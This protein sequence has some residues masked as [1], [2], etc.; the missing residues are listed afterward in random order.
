MPLANAKTLR[1]YDE[2]KN[3]GNRTHIVILQTHWPAW[4][5]G[6]CATA[7]R[8]P[9]RCAL[10]RCPLVACDPYF[11]IWSPADKLT[12]AD[13]VHWTGKPHRLRSVVRIDGKEF[14]VMGAGAPPS[15]HCRKK[16]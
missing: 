3:T 8:P 12:D 10:P 15:P 9:P 1:N 2:D 16:A 5:I 4:F 6:K 13:T 14:R 7:T 11:S